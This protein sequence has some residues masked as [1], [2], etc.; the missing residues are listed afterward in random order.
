MQQSGLAVT[1][2]HEPSPM[3]IVYGTLLTFVTE[4]ILSSHFQLL[5]SWRYIGNSVK[6]CLWPCGIG[7]VG[8]RAAAVPATAQMV[9]TLD[10]W[11]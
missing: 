7:N 9:R 2:Y 5:K 1:F 10:L 8:D 3:R 11:C 6:A 4:A